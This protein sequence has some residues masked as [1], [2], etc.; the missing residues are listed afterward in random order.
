MDVAEAGESGTETVGAEAW[1]A[2]TEIDGTAV[3]ET[4]GVGEETEAGA[5]REARLGIEA[6]VKM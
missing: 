6:E 3:A 5:R 2:G 4:T 1:A